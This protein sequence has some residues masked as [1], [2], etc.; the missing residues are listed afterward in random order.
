MQASP[1]S[2]R[3]PSNQNSLLAAGHI[4]KCLTRMFLF[5]NP[6]DCHFDGLRPICSLMCIQ[7]YSDLTFGLYAVSLY[8]LC[9]YHESYEK[10]RIATTKSTAC[11]SSMFAYFL[12]FTMFLR[13]RPCCLMTEWFLYTYGLVVKSLYF[14]KHCN[15]KRNR[16]KPR[17]I[18]CILVRT[19]ESKLMDFPGVK[20]PQVS[21]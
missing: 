3:S 20:T 5:H 16:T 15:V 14:C 18:D 10:V 8:L 1:L 19:K 4:I 12:Y 13:P 7:F 2:I 6:S 11:W 9:T 17:K 21:H